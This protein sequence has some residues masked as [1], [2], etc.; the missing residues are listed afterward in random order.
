MKIGSALVRLEEII[1]AN[2]MRRKRE[3]KN[4]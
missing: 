3:A 4:K 2:K 1:K